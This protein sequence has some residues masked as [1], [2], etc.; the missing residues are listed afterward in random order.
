MAT[1]PK[2]TIYIDVD[3]EITTVIDKVMSSDKKLVALV[4]PKRASVF[5]SIVNMKL[6]KR[7][8]DESSKNIVLVT[9]DSSIMPLAGAVGL[10]VAHNL[11]SKP[12][13][14]SA[15][16]IGKNMVEASE[17]EKI[18]NINPD[19]GEGTIDLSKMAQ[20]EESPK[21]SKKVNEAKKVTSQPKQSAKSSIK[22]PETIEL[23]NS[24][25][26]DQ[27]EKPMD[28]AMPAAAVAADKKKKDK[29]P[30]KDKVK[31]P[32]FER[33]R[34]ISILSIIAIVVIVILWVVLFKVLP[35][36]TINIKTNAQ[37]V[38]ANLTF[39]LNNNA[40]SFSLSNDILPAKIVSETKTY[41]AT[42]NST[43]QQNNGK[44]A[45]GSVT[46]TVC[47]QQ[48]PLSTPNPIPAG[49]GITQNNLTYVT[50]SK[51]NFSY[52]TTTI[53]CAYYT[54]S[55]VNI[56]AQQGGSSYNT[57]NNNTQFNVS[58]YGNNISAVGGAS[59]GTDNIVTVV[60]QQDITNAEN[61][62]TTNNSG[63]QSYLISQLTQNNYYPIKATFNA[64]KPNI[65]P[66]AA[67]G[68]IANSVTVTETIRYTM[69][70]VNKSDLIKLLDSNIKSQV[71]AGQ[72]I[73]NSGLSTAT[74]TVGSPS[75]SITMSTNAIVGPN[76][77]VAKL[78]QEISGKNV[79]Q[80]DSL[81]KSNP[82]VSGVSVKLS[83]FYVS[84]AP[85]PSKI[86]IKIAKPTNNPSNA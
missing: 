41:T 71:G 53:N 72:S 60:S 64:S 23:D 33:F 25:E 38:N 42:V 86:N 46:F 28:T 15:P 70:G 1:D 7:K 67:V 36:A 52:D 35:Q 49:T 76:I 24:D 51:A 59:G 62:I 39:T 27:E 2:D 78:K 85:S 45:T 54:S 65:S 16:V 26:V 3:D 81:I 68:T 84:T 22:D 37:N 47:E 29:K 69:Y 17:D 77:N 14:P 79:N 30:A 74:Y 58:G 82:D 66:N 10:H 13:I 55:N 4:L 18:A 43:G 8:G 61:K 21:E 19:T 6:L 57:P 32:N 75:N 44:Q 34:M 5:Q 73:L 31:V 56:T 9:A 50:D 83:P 12:E 48:F 63:A 11:N 20:E 80:I 40:N